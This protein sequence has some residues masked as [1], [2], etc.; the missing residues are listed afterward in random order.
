MSTG[1]KNLIGRE[2]NKLTSPCSLILFKSRD[3][4]TGLWNMCAYKPKKNLKTNKKWGAINYISHESDR[5]LLSSIPNL[6]AC[7]WYCEW[8]SGGGCCLFICDYLAISFAFET[9]E[10]LH[11]TGWLT[12]KKSIFMKLLKKHRFFFFQSMDQSKQADIKLLNWIRK[13]FIKSISAY[14]L[15]NQPFYGVSWTNKFLL[16]II[17]FSP[18]ILENHQD[19]AQNNRLQI[20]FILK[21]FF[22]GK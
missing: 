8:Q 10:L 22:Q 17:L 11:E 18:E 13:L 21:C 14:G 5:Q 2:E 9:G 4:G 16:S 3:T 7:A 6:C 20:S 12:W 19:V 15:L 1:Y